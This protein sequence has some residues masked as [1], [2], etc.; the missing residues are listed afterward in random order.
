MPARQR[1]LS[2]RVLGCE[3]LHIKI[4]S[5]TYLA[6]SPHAFFFSF[7]FLFLF[8]FLPPLP[9]LSFFLALF[10]ACTFLLLA[11]LYCVHLFR[12]LVLLIRILPLLCRSFPIAPR[13]DATGSSARRCSD[14]EGCFKAET[15]LCVLL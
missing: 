15:Y 4:N 11:A 9:H 2:L 3:H 8:L 5:V 10:T 13:K 1:C 14:T 7:L 12:P 6:F